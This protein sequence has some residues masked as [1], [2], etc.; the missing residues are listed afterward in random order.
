MINEINFGRC[1]AIYGARANSPASEATFAFLKDTIGQAVADDYTTFVTTANDGYEL[2]AARFI[3]ELKETF[4]DISLIVVQPYQDRDR[5]WKTIPI[6]RDVCNKA[7]M[8]KYITDSDDPDALFKTN[9]W[10]VNHCDR[11]ICTT[12]NP[13]T[14]INRLQN[15]DLTGKEVIKVAVCMSEETQE[16]V[17]A[18]TVEI[19]KPAKPKYPENLLCDIL[20]IN[21]YDHQEISNEFPADI[22]DRIL[23]VISRSGTR[24]EK[25]LK[26]RYRDNLTL[27][28]IAEQFDLSRERIRQILVKLLKKLRHPKNM[29]ILKGK[30]NEPA[31]NT[32]NM[33]EPEPGADIEPETPSEQN[34]TLKPEPNEPTND[35]PFEIDTNFETNWT[36]WPEDE[37]NLIRHEIERLNLSDIAKLHNRQPLSVARLIKTTHMLSDEQFEAYVTDIDLGAFHSTDKLNSYERWTPEENKH[38]L[39]LYKQGFNLNMMAAAHQRTKGAIIARLSKLT[40]QKRDDIRRQFQ[41]NTD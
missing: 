32:A 17:H 24:A 34:P 19:K 3:C 23:S 8:V 18:D 28:E 12:S 25:I 15:F 37:I 40:G 27:Q 30:L 41:K 11:I 14:S 9:Q 10:I 33:A 38:L 2:D 16:Y 20:N 31:S 29:A 35:T 1:C 36:I 22:E 13:Y 26:L 5:Y 39:T 7:D 6:F 4:S 21:W